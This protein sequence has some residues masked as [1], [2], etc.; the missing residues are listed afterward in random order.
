MLGARFLREHR[1]GVGPTLQDSWGTLRK[2][3]SNQMPGL[4]QMRP[5]RL[6][7]Y[8]KLRSWTEP[9]RLPRILSMPTV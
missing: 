6:H 7:S 8:Q 1:E 9:R 4:T 5:W 3:T 2:C